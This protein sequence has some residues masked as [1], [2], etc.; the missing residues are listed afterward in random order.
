MFASL[1]KNDDRFGSWLYFFTHLCM[2]NC[3][4][5][6]VTLIRLLSFV[7]RQNPT[8]WVVGSLVPIVGGVVLASATEASF[9]W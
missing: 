7:F 6:M 1:N 2:A 4:L 3:E 9:N 5:V 8:A